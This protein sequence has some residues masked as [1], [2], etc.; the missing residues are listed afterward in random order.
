M[1]ILLGALAFVVGFAFDWASW[2]R[3]PY[4]G[5]LGLLTAITFATALVW[6]LSNPATWLWPWYISALGWPL[7]GVGGALLVYSLFVEL[8]STATYLRPGVGE[9][10]VTTGT[11]A[12]VRHPGVLWFAIWMLGWVLVSPSRTVAWA[13]VLWLLFDI[14]YVWLQE[15]LLFRRMFPDYAAYERETPM[16]VPTASS[17][18][19]C[20]QTLPF[21]NRRIAS[22]S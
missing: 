10:L 3:K 12:L 17:I 14:V 13:G 20:W 1:A 19:R 21:R 22:S 16:L 4:K 9:A 2:R 15:L 8:P 11:Y 6:V 5:L 18:R 7:V